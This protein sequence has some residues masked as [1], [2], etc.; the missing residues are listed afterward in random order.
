MSV[1]RIH[2]ILLDHVG[3]DLGISFGGE[4]M[5]LF[6]KLLLQRNVVLD[7]A[8]VHDHDAAGAVA[9][10][11]SIFFC[12]SAVRRPAGVANTVGAVQRLEA[13]DLFQVAK[14]ALRPANLQAFT[15][16]TDRDPGRIVAAI[17]QSPETIKNDGNDPL[18]ANI[19][20]NSAHA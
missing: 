18:L 5:A 11:V 10:R 7:D 16:A 14:F 1:A 15:V 4:F 13:N 9:V 19:P 12:W 3:D 2:V 17:L 6:G 20:N 8:V